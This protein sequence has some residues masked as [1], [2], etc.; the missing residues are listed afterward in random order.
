MKLQKIT[1]I[2]LMFEF[3]DYILVSHLGMSGTWR[4]G[5]RNQK[6]DHIQIEFSN[7]KVFTFHDPRRFGYICLLPKKDWQKHKFFSHLGP[8][9][10]GKDFSADYLYAKTRKKQQAIKNFIMDQK[11]VVGVGNIY[12]S[13]A[14]FLSG[15]RPSKRAFKLTRKQSQALVENIKVVLKKAIQAGG[16]YIRDF[17][18]IEGAASFQRQLY[19]YGK[20][21]CECKHCGHRIK[22]IVQAGRSSFYCPQCQV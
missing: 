16:S 6:H 11:I 17:L 22:K 3:E 18:N 8:E 4:E 20:A 14:L 12:A 10:L 19:V 2:H 1:K 21:E 15:I 5:V 7:G 9:P 13:E